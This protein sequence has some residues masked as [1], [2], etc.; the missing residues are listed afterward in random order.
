MSDTTT[1]RPCF[2]CGHLHDDTTPGA[3]WEADCLPECPAHGLMA[4]RSEAVRRN[5]GW[6]A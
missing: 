6:S 4:N 3:C 2:A 5:V 1:P